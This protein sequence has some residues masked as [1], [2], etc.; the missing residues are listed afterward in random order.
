MECEENYYLLNDDKTNCYNDPIDNE[1]YISEDD[2]KKYISC[3]RFVPHCDK[4]QD[5][6]TFIA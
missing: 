2:R 1:R 6:E 3:D 5:R 4:C